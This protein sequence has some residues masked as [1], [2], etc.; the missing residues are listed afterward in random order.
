MFNSA[1]SAVNQQDRDE[2]EACQVKRLRARAPKTWESAAEWHR[3]RRLL[4]RNLER[5]RHVLARVGTTP[6]QVEYI[7][8]KSRPS[9]GGKRL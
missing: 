5:S 9:S 7:A 2:E 3:C 1:V 6:S 8:G 4:G